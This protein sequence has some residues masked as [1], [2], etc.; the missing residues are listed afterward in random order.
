MEAFGAVVAGTILTFVNE[1][2]NRGTGHLEDDSAALRG[3]G[4]RVLGPGFLP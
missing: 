1:L 4:R 2:V 3:G